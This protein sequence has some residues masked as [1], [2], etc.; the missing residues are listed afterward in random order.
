MFPWPTGVRLV[1]VA[2]IVPR[3]VRFTVAL[4]AST[5]TASASVEST[6]PPAPTVICPPPASVAGIATLVEAASVSASSMSIV[7]EPLATLATMAEVALCIRGEP[8]GSV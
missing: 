8:A 1:V 7:V 3:L 6:E 5:S 2:W 4:A